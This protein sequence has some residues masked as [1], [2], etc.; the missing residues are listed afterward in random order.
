MTFKKTVA[1]STIDSGSSA[2]RRIQRM[3]RDKAQFQKTR[4]QY[5][6]QLDAAT[7]VYT[8]YILSLAQA[9]MGGT[10]KTP[11]LSGNL[12]YYVQLVRASHTKQALWHKTAPVDPNTR[13][14]AMDQGISDL[15]LRQSISETLRLP[16]GRELTEIESEAARLINELSLSYPDPDSTE[17]FTTL[18]THGTDIISIFELGKYCEQYDMPCLLGPTQFGAMNRS[19][20]YRRSLTDKA[21]LTFYTNDAVPDVLDVEW[22]GKEYLWK[23]ENLVEL[24]A[25]YHTMGDRVILLLSCVSSNTQTELNLF[26]Y[27]P[28]LLSKLTLV[29]GADFIMESSPSRAEFEAALGIAE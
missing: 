26:L 1:L 28:E 27:Y 24:V 3:F 13:P 2:A 8:N 20:D 19:D 5:F 22:D 6:D 4:E 29:V 11:V 23:Q 7:E 15:G 21:G 25:H 14:E 9:L 17:L 16:D 10:Y 18:K 12:H